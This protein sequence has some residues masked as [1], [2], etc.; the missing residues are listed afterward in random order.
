MWERGQKQWHDEALIHPQGTKRASREWA[1][2]AKKH[3]RNKINPL[4][5]PRS[6]LSCNNRWAN[7]HLC[8]DSHG[9]PWDYPATATRLQRLPSN[10]AEF[11]PPSDGSKRSPPP[12]NHPHLSLQ[13][14][15]TAGS[16]DRYQKKIIIK[17]QTDKN[18]WEYIW[19][20]MWWDCLS[21]PFWH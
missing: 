14:P 16:T 9:L 6:V 11:T 15:A 18:V 21:I 12:Q 5:T 13:P 20:A 8:A 7:T 10:V 3:Q 1:I 2:H 19:E 4:P 17:C